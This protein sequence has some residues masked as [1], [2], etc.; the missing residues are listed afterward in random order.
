MDKPTRFFINTE[1][2]SGEVTGRLVA[3]GK[4]LLTRFDLMR[5]AGM[6]GDVWTQ[7]T[8]EGIVFKLD[9]SGDVDNVKIFMPSNIQEKEAKEEYE[10][11][12]TEDWVL[13]LGITSTDWKLLGVLVIDQEF[14]LIKYIKNDG[15]ENFDGFDH[16]DRYYGFKSNWGNADSGGKLEL[17]ELERRSEIEMFYVS[18][19]STYNNYTNFPGLEPGSFIEWNGGSPAINWLIPGLYGPNLGGGYWVPHDDGSTTWYTFWDTAVCGF[20][21]ED[22][23]HILNY[24]Y[25][26]VDSEGNIIDDGYVY[27]A[28]IW[29]PD[30][31]QRSTFTEEKSYHRVYYFKASNGDSSDTILT[32]DYTFNHIWYS[33]YDGCYTDT[34]ETL[35]TEE[36]PQYQYVDGTATCNNP[37]YCLPND[38]APFNKWFIYDELSAAMSLS[39]SYVPWEY[40]YIWETGMSSWRRFT[41]KMVKDYVYT[42]KLVFDD[43]HEEI[44]KS[45]YTEGW[46]QYS[47]YGIYNIGSKFIYVGNLGYVDENYDYSM[48]L[49]YYCDEK[50]KISE[51]SQP[52]YYQCAD[53]F[54]CVKEC[55][56]YWDGQVRVAKL[57]KTIRRKKI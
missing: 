53:L 18:D 52:N 19:D 32:D 21:W 33:W 24:H 43:G 36:V 34:N 50:F 51:A 25:Q 49:F 29:P 4:Q 20:P 26:T 16:W 45:G 9:K 17:E 55:G 47:D 23:F 42:M 35:S 11:I 31:I 28:H 1:Q 57:K 7:R 14:N 56:G 40:E 44:V 38:I 8:N 54:N 6:V 37:K 48:Q 27:E 5:E 39:E 13:M 15:S 10:E 2:L 41:R 30:G 3:M 22:F 12:V 46:H